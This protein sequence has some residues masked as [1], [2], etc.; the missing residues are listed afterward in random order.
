[1]ERKRG[2]ARGRGSRDHSH[3]PTGTPLA[4]S[5]SQARSSPLPRAPCTSTTSSHR[6]P[7]CRRACR[8]GGFLGHS[9][10][11]WFLLLLPPGP[12]QGTLHSP[13]RPLNVAGFLSHTQLNTVGKQSRVGVV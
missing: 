12:A 3:L 5:P 13:G 4:G 8:R 1:M 11:R 2:C 9:S 6:A 7:S 10:A